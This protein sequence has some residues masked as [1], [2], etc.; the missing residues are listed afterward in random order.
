MSNLAQVVE[1]LNELDRRSAHMAIGVAEMNRDGVGNIATLSRLREPFSLISFPP[2]SKMGCPKRRKRA[3]PECATR[4]HFKTLDEAIVSANTMIK[5]NRKSK[6][7]KPLLLHI[8][9][10]GMK[11]T[12]HRYS[13]TAK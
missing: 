10:N 8:T 12:V 11:M 5:L 6:H 9:D 7:P 1:Q 4:W 3:K 2:S 13:S